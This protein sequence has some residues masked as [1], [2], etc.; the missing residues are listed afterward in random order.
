[1][2]SQQDFWSGWRC[3]VWQAAVMCWQ[4]NRV[5]EKG[6]IRTTHTQTYKYTHQCTNIYVHK[7]QI[8]SIRHEKLCACLLAQERKKERKSHLTNIFNLKQSMTLWPL[9]C[10]NGKHIV[11]K[12][13]KAKHHQNRQEKILRHATSLF[14]MPLM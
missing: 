7:A 11:A 1:M 6:V 13:V 5:Q 12:S 2:T 4:L 10:W 8:H 3:R 14:Y 9:S